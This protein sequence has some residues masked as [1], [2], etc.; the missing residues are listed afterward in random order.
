MKALLP[1]LILLLLVCIGLFVVALF[2]PRR[3]AR[4]QQRYDDVSRKAESKGGESGGRLGDLAEGA[5]EKGRAAADGSAR[6]GRNLHR[7]VA[8]K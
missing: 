1:L 7:K 8:R 6:A 5:L 3:A 2:S 4:M